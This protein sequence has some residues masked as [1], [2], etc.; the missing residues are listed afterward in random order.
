MILFVCRSGVNRSKTASD[1]MNELGYNADYTGL[2][3]ADEKLPDAQVVIFMEP[4]H[5]RFIEEFYP[6]ILKN[7]KVYC[8]N[9]PDSFDFNEARLRKR[10][11]KK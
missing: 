8:L 6:G 3:Y 9:I 5:I 2:S 7:K 4:D 11:I 10:I 1:M